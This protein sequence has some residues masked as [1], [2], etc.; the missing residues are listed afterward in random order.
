MPNPQKIGSSS[1]KRPKGVKNYVSTFADFNSIIFIFRFK[2]SKFITGLNDLI[3]KDDVSIF[4]SH[5]RVK[6]Y[7]VVM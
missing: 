3:V 1:H 5:R 7:D 2:N 4:G 6:S